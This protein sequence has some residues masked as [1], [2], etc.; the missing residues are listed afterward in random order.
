LGGVQPTKHLPLLTDIH[1]E[2]LK[3]L[4]PLGIRPIIIGTA[5]S[6]D[7]TLSKPL[8]VDK[9]APTPVALV[10]ALR[11][12]G[13][14]VLG[15]LIQMGRSADD[16]II[17]IPVVMKAGEIAELRV[18]NA[19]NA[20]SAY[21]AIAEYS[22]YCTYVPVSTVSRVQRASED[23]KPG[24][25]VFRTVNIGGVVVLWKYG[26]EEWEKPLVA[27]AMYFVD[28]RPEEEVM[29]DMEELVGREH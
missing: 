22:T 4:E 21:E 20:G 24:K 2:L 12:H 1:R 5:E 11:D 28:S 15:E 6:F 3:I 19:P 7:I 17:R 29:K 14:R 9:L 26:L 10:Q 18:F 16:W 27:A 8:P 25:A 23:M 13:Y